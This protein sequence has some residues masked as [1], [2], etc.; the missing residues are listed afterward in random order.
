MHRKSELLRRS[1]GAQQNVQLNDFEIM[2]ELGRGSYG[3]VY[4][5]KMIRSGM[6]YAMKSIR[7]DKLIEKGV[8]ENIR[9]ELEILLSVEHP[10]L[11]GIDYFFQTEVRLYFVLPYIEGGDMYQHL[12]AQRRLPEHM[13]MFYMTQIV[14]GLGQLHKQGVIH[15]DLKL[16]N[17]MICSNGYIKLIDYGLAHQLMGADSAS[18]YVGT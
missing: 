5:V 18:S 2:Y 11:C 10:F 14:L 8:V 4:L 17:I 6:L 13:I 1:A 15:R 3:T 16:E 12:S 7:K 9:L